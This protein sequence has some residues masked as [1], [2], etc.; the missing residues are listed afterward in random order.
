MDNNFKNQESYYIEQILLL[1]QQLDEIQLQYVN[2]FI[3]ERFSM[4]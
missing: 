4:E 3:R 1:L 2:A